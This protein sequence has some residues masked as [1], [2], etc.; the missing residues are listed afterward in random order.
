MDKDENINILLGLEITLISQIHNL[1][2]EYMK[3]DVSDD[4]LD[5]AKRVMIRKIESDFVFLKRKLFF[6]KA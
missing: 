6:T 5:Q 2:N 1:I 4:Y 3:D